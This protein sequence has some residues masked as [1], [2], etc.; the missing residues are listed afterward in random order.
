MLSGLWLVSDVKSEMM[1][2]PFQGH[3]ISGYDTTKSKF[4]EVWVDSM[5][6]SFSHGEGTCDAAGKVISTNWEGPGPD[7][8]MMKWRQTDEMK[9]ADSRVMTMYQ[10]G[11]DGKESTMMTINYK[12]KK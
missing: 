4:V 6:T 11:A 5:G 7:G 8:K 1:G 10:T 3:S 12:R 2:M 9:D